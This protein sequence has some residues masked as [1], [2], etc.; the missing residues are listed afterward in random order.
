MHT[1][2]HTCIH[3][4]IYA[5]THTH[6]RMQHLD[7]GWQSFDTYMHTYMNTCMHTHTHIHT[8]SRYWVAKFLSQTAPSIHAARTEYLQTTCIHTYTHARTHSISILGG[9]VSVTDSSIDSCG[10]YGVFVQDGG[11]FEGESLTISRCTK[12]GLLARGEGTVAI[13]R[14]ASKLVCIDSCFCL[15]ARVCVCVCVCTLLMRV[16][17]ANWYVLRVVPACFQCMCLLERERGCVCWC[18]VSVFM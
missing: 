12:T 14:G 11:S 15:L 1:Y 13:A 9:K 8:T 7:T 17:R 16:A 18:V 4:C 6:T 10:E 3:T 2:M 5:Y